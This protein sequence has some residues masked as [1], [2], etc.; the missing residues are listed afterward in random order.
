MASTGNIKEKWK[1]LGLWNVFFIGEFLLAGFGYLTLNLL[2]NVLLLIFVMFPLQNRWLRWLRTLAAVCAAFALVYSESWLPGLES[3]KGNF[4]NVAA[5]ETGYIVDSLLNFLNFEMIGI[6]LVL[7]VVYYAIRDYVRV[8]TFTIGYLVILLLAPVWQPL[9]QRPAPVPAETV[10]AADSAKKEGAEEVKSDLI[11]QTLDPTSRNLDEWL[12]T[13][14][15]TEKDRRAVWPDSLPKTDT[16]FDILLL[17]ICSLSNSDLKAVGLDNHEVLQKFN[18][19]FENFNSATSY[20]GPAALRLL[21]SACGQPSHEDLYEGRNP[22][23]EIMSRLGHLGYNQYVF[24]DHSGKYDNFYQSLR[25]LA[26]LTPR[27]EEM[28][29]P[30]RYD[31][32]DEEPIGDARAVFKD[33][34][35]TA[36]SSDH[37]SATFVNLI[38]LHDGNRFAGKRRLAPF[39]PRAKAM[40]DDLDTL[41]SDIEKS[42]RKVML[43]VVPEHGAAEQGDKVQVAHL[44]D[45]PSPSITHVPALRRSK[46]W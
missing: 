7:I 5:M 9:F 35:K 41:I 18:I 28:K 15:D 16:P 8:T 45:I 40:L 1:G 20:S 38:A 11:P 46:S 32:F 44:R 25:H 30:K 13:F 6:G 22:D 36:E 29:Y 31:S 3:I 34:E 37:K 19:R 23:C 42:G 27:L 24:M 2:H 39:K 33:W 26:G 14:H 10:A 4:H 43:V 12:K 21:K 17:N